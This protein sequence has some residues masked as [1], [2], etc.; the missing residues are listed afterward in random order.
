[1]G[2]FILGILAIILLQVIFFGYTSRYWSIPSEP[3]LVKSRPS[4][5][6]ARQPNQNPKVETPSAPV[7]ES[8]SPAPQTQKRSEVREVAV[9]P[10]SPAKTSAHPIR[11]RVVMN[12]DTSRTYTAK[13]EPRPFDTRLT[14]VIPKGHTMVL[15]DNLP[16]AARSAGPG[17]TAS[18][19]VVKPRKRSLLAK[20][21]SV[22]VKKPWGWMKSLA[23]KLD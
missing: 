10:A 21:F 16:P 22:V 7:A 23:S 14:T 15:V 17:A 6:D 1:M 11:K 8:A 9:A 19:D 13:T 18:A 4:V 2:K 3:G 12:R 20:S 5:P